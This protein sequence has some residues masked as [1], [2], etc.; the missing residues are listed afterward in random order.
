MDRPYQ[1]SWSAQRLKFPV[2]ILTMFCTWL[3]FEDL[4]AMAAASQ[5][6]WRAACPFLWQN[7]RSLRF[8]LSAIAGEDVDSIQMPSVRQAVA[9]PV[10]ASFESGFILSRLTHRT[11]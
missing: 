11:S 10:G 4:R 8:L 9:P 6:C 2:E 7:V 3:A 1:F 5:Y